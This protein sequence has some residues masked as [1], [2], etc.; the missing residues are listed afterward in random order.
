MLIFGSLYSLKSPENYSKNHH[1]FM[2]SDFINKWLRSRRV[3]NMETDFECIIKVNNVYKCCT[4]LVSKASFGDLWV[5]Y[6]RCLCAFDTE[7]TNI[8]KLTQSSVILLQGCLWVLC[9]VP[10]CCTLT[11]VII[12]IWETRLYEICMNSTSHAFRLQKWFEMFKMVK[13]FL[14]TRL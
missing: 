14:T 12:I 11:S 1:I 8:T 5:F 6:S 2:T 4:P 3:Q 7:A 13:V 10:S 9:W